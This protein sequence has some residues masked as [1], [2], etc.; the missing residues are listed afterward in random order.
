ME[1]FRATKRI[2]ICAL[3]S[4]LFLLFSCSHLDEIRS[5]TTVFRGMTRFCYEISRI[6]LFQPEFYIRSNWRL[7]ECQ[8]FRKS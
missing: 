3:I 2:V 4:K 8:K 7:T 5:A 6:W 1:G